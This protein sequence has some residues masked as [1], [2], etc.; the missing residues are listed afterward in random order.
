MQEGGA[1]DASSLF[2]F[3]GFARRRLLRFMYLV[4]IFFKDIQSI[5]MVVLHA[6]RAEDG[7]HGA[8]R[9]ALLANHLTDVTG[10]HP[11]AK[12][13]ILITLNCVDNHRTRFVDEGPG[14]LCTPVPAYRPV[15]VPCV[16][17]SPLPS[18]PSPGTHNSCAPGRRVA[19]RRS[20]SV[21]L[22]TLRSETIARQSIDSQGKK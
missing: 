6:H 2:G 20:A 22:R 5:A 13:S 15:S 10:S 14:D 16:R 9:A 4:T 21:A 12:D 11:Q 1:R 18:S 7:A 19:G 17:P 3:A 8:R